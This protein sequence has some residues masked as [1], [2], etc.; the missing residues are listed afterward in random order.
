MLD[1]AEQLAELRQFAFE[2]QSR[3]GGQ[4][5]RDADCRRMRAVHGAERVFDEDVVAVRQLAGERGVVLRLALVEPRVLEDANPFVV[6]QFAEALTHGLHRI[7][8]I[9]PFR[10]PEV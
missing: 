2:Q 7:L 6:E 1:V 5:L 10:P 9:L 8:R 3:V 4:Q